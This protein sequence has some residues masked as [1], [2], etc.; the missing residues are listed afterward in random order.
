MHWN[1]SRSGQHILL[2]ATLSRGK[3]PTIV[4][5]LLVIF[6]FIVLVVILVAVFVKVFSGRQRN[7]RRLHLA[8]LLQLY[9]LQ[10]LEHLHG[11]PAAPLL[12]TRLLQGG[13]V[14]PCRVCR[15]CTSEHEADAQ[16]VS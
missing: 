6:I 4:T 5:V 2:P 3:R 1:K 10:Q 9:L 14:T 15:L 7:G 8:P 13:G 16:V 11:M 12:G